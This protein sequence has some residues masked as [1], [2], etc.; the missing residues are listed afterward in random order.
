VGA[1][2]HSAIQ[3]GLIAGWTI[4]RD[5]SEVETVRNYWGLMPP[6]SEKPGFGTDE[7]YLAAEVDSASDIKLLINSYIGRMRYKS[8]GSRPEQQYK[9]VWKNPDAWTN[10]NTGSALSVEIRRVTDPETGNDVG[11]ELGDKV[12]LIG[13]DVE[14]TSDDI[15]LQL[16][17]LEGGEFWID[18]GRF[19]VQW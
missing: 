14:I 8:E 15:V 18:T 5:D 19:E 17:T 9:L 13:S 12:E 2:L 6:D 11:L 7:P 1:A 16:C 10:V 3:N 4:I